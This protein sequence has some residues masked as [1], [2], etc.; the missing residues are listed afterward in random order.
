MQA[1]SLP[2]SRE[3]RSMDEHVVAAQGRSDETEA[4]VVVPPRELAVEAHYAARILSDS[5][6]STVRH[7][8]SS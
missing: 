3:G 5:I 7:R 2:V 1:R 4:A 6:G 8:C